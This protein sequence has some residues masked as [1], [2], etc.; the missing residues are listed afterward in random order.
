MCRNDRLMFAYQFG[1]TGFERLGYGAGGL[2]DYLQVVYCSDLKQLIIP[3]GIE[4]S[5][6]PPADLRNCL[7][8]V[9]HAVRVAPHRV[10]ASR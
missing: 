1:M 10:T 7:Q 3:K 2:S 6:N 9:A 8:D 5:Y 4:A